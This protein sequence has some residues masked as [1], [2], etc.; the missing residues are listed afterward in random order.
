M[1]DRQG[2]DYS[3]M[4]STLLPPGSKNIKSDALSSLFSF[5]PEPKVISSILPLFCFDG[6]VTKETE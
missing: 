4:G 6:S 5:D 2:G 3:L 1:P